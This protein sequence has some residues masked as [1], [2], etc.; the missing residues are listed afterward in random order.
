MHAVILS[1]GDELVLGQTVDTN[2]AWL[3][4][5]LTSLGVWPRRHLTVADEQSEVRGALL[6]GKRR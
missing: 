6:A 3:S 4:A 5:Q 1:I 2:S